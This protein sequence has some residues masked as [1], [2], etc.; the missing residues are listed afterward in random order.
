MAFRGKWMELE[1]IMLSRVNWFIRKK[2]VCS[3]SCAESR[4]NIYIYINMTIVKRLSGGKKKKN[5]RKMS[6]CILSMY[7]DH[8]R[9]PTESC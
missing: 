2:F 1:I 7:E 6:K 5:D 3:L 8:T 9:Q 4:P